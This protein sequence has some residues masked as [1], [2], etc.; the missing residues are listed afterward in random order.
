MTN[1][2]VRG[3]KIK[4][5]PLFGRVDKRCRPRPDISAL[6][7]AKW[8]DPEFRERMKKRDEDRIADLKANP[9]KYSRAGIPTGHTRASVQPLWDRA[10][11][12]ADRFIKIMQDKGELPKDEIVSVDVRD[13]D[14]KVVDTEQVTVPTTDDG[15]AVAALK[16]AFVLAVGPS[17]QKIKIQAINT[18]LNFTKSKPESKSK[19]TLNKAEDFL[20]SIMGDD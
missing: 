7:K 15:K 1:K 3:V 11:E 4:K 2:T 18:V 12:L 20:D 10:R 5:I 9:E 19:L 14:G 13:A 8:Q 16:E 6:Q 17:D